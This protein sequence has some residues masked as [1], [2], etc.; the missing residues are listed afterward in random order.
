MTTIPQPIIDPALTQARVLKRALDAGALSL[1]DYQAM[2]TIVAAKAE[3]DAQTC[4]APG[5]TRPAQIIWKDV[6]LCAVCAIS[7]REAGLLPFD[8]S[9][10]T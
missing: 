1:H 6:P 8:D 4:H 2:Y 5:C 10:K 3:R 7:R 9:R